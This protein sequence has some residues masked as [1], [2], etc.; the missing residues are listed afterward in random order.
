M[1]SLG[2]LLSAPENP[3]AEARR[4]FVLNPVMPNLHGMFA[5]LKPADL[6]QNR[7]LK[8]TIDQRAVLKGVLRDRLRADEKVLAQTVFPG[9]D[10]VNPTPGLLA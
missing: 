8:P 9:S 4:F 5:A 1:L 2:F 10:A 7:D 6:Y 3:S